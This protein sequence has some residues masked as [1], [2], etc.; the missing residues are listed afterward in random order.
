MVFELKNTQVRV[1]SKLYIKREK[2]V[3][4]NSIKVNQSRT[5]RVL[6]HLSCHL[7]WDLELLRQLLHLNPSTN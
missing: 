1:V 3:S 7:C 2:K 6:R 4:L 5:H